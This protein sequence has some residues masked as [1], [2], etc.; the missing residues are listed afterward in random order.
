MKDPPTFSLRGPQRESKDFA[1]K[2]RNRDF[3]GLRYP[4]FLAFP[5]R[6]G[7]DLIFVEGAVGGSFSLDL[8]YICV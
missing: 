5:Q 1:A 6:T 2:V 3:N 7:R 4:Y 8:E